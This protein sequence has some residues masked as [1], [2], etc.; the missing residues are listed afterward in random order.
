MAGT[1][2]CFRRGYI[3]HMFSGALKN[4]YA[5]VKV[6]LLVWWI[7]F[8]LLYVLFWPVTSKWSW[9]FCHICFVAKSCVQ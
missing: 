4:L 2:F 8:F 6:P 3:E 9:Q 7:F 1:E 5:T